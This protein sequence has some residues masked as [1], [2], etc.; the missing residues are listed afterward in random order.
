MCWI[1][2]LFF[3][4]YRFLKFNICN[5]LVK[6]KSLLQNVCHIFYFY[7]QNKNELLIIDLG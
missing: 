7:D 3:E 2:Y 5:S 1:L 6:K 4:D